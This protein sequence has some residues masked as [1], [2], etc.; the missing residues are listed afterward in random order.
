MDKFEPNE[1]YLSML[2]DIKQKVAQNQPLAAMA[3]NSRLTYLYWLIGNHILVEQE[4]QGWGAK[5]I[6]QLESDLRVAFPKMRGFS[7]RNLTYMRQ[8]ANAWTKDMLEKQ[9]QEQALIEVQPFTQ[10]GVAQIENKS[11]IVMT[12]QGAA[13]LIKK[14][15]LDMPE[16]L[17]ITFEAFT[18][19]PISCIPWSTHMVLLD[20]VSS[21]K[22]RLFYCI[23]TTEGSWSRNVLMNK[24]EQNLYETQGTLPNNFATTLPAPQS[25]LVRDTFKN[26]Y[27]FGFLQLGDEA[28]ERAV[29]DKLTK[30]ITSFILELGA[31]FAY[32]GRQFK[33]EVGGQEYFLD[34]VFYH[35]KLKRYVVIEL[36]IG[37]FK[38]EFTG[39]LQF[40]LSAFDDIVK[41]ASDNDTIGLILCKE[42]NHIVAEYA[43]RDSSKPMGIAKYQLVDALPDQLK[44]QLPTKEQ[45]EASLSEPKDE[46]E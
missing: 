36:K 8:F 43:L 20:K 35:V 3:V 44:D 37:E 33:L 40:Y 19:H 42:A 14:D 23:K 41:Q 10:Q 9:L 25:E 26:P 28:S 15:K 24:L 45:I 32:M 22:E 6:G 18:M 11:G 31:G 27:F 29:E 2:E 16:Q 39:K 30:Q 21:P 12:Q 38:P 1:G 17:E 13:Q 7:K 4:R 46:K 34:L 5:V